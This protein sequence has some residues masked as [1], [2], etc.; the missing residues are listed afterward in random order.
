MLANVV[1]QNQFEG[2]ITEGAGMHLH[3]SS[4]MCDMMLVKDVKPNA[5]K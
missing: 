1:Q 4:E 5:I 2:S 3:T